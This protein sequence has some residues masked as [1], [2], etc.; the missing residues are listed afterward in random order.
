[1]F[2][3]A[4]IVETVS[5]IEGESVT[6]LSNFTKIQKDDEIEWRLN[7]K[8]IAVI[9]GGSITT[10][11]AFRDGLQLDKQTGDLKITNI[12]TTDSGEYKL[13]IKNTRGSSVQTFS[14][15]GECLSFL[16]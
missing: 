8:H 10:N 6:L 9:S 4:D 16:I 3:D 12:R 15:K 7:E 1:V 11:G 5:A 13:N 2:G 14:V